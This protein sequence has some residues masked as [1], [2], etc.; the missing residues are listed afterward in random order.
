MN[1]N[2]IDQL[3]RAY[4]KRDYSLVEVLKRGMAKDDVKAAEI[5]LRDIRLAQKPVYF[6]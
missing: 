5:I 4:Q 1:Q 6:K 2:N 3:V